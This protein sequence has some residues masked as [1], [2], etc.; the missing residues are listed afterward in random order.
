MI[1]LVNG[2]KILSPRLTI[3]PDTFGTEVTMEDK[4]GVYYSCRCSKDTVI[5]IQEELTGWDLKG[6]DI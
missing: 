6:I 5:T 1:I 3:M 4:S 2:Q